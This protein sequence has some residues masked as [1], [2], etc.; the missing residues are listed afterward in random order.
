MFYLSYSFE[1]RPQRFSN[2]PAKNKTTGEGRGIMVAFSVAPLCF[3]SRDF[4]YTV[5]LVNAV[6]NSNFN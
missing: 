3:D 2:A 4:V 1:N 6:Y 5:N